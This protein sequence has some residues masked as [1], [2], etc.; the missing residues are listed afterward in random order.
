MGL[1]MLKGVLLGDF[2]SSFLA[3]TLMS[4]QILLMLCH[5]NSFTHSS[6][7]LRESKATFVQELFLT[8]AGNP[9]PNPLSCFYV[10]TL[11]DCIVNCVASWLLVK[12]ISSVI[13]W[14]HSIF[15]FVGAGSLS[16]FCYLFSME[17]SEK[18]TN[19]IANYACAS[20]G[21]FAGFATLSL[22]LPRC[23]TPLFKRIPLT[24]FGT[25]Y[26]IICLHN[27]YIEP[28]RTE[29]HR[30]IN[31]RLEN[32]SF[33]GG[34]FFALMYSSLFFQTRAGFGMRQIFYNN[35]KN[36]AKL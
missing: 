24:L 33:V 12:P 10:H 17:A 35:I 5:Y 22:I 26:L 25:F 8:R 21:A 20:N 3:T 4:E 30:A 11:R 29:T 32:R 36:A 14:R 6:W 2:A 27:E 7:A 13:G 9:F 19:N 15:L 18:N 34:V 1:S 16:S 23:Y 28:G 31:I